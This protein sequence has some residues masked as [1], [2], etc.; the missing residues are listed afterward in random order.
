MTD[1]T[2]SFEVLAPWLGQQTGQVLQQ[3]E[4]PVAFH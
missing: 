2:G 3:Q 4:L 1:S